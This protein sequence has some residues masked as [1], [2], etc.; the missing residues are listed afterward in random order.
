[1]LESC[2][3]CWLHMYMFPGDHTCPAQQCDILYT[4][5]VRLTS[6]EHHGRLQ[7]AKDDTHRVRMVERLVSFGST[8]HSSPLPCSLGLHSAL[9]RRCSQ[10]SLGVHLIG[11]DVADK[12]ASRGGS[13]RSQGVG[14]HHARC[15]TF[16]L[17]R[18][19]YYT[20]LPGKNSAWQ[21]PSALPQYVKIM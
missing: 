14:M 16:T 3:C 2:C 4:R 21:M 10:A 1:M 11:A 19:A 5:T 12:I 9:G 17:V 18:S 6:S 7:G 20:W 15:L 13:D 8:A